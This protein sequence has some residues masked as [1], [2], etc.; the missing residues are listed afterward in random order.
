MIRRRLSAQNRYG[1]PPD[2]RTVM[3]IVLVPVL[4]FFGAMAGRIWYLAKYYP[5]RCHTL[6]IASHL[7]PA[8]L[9]APFPLANHHVA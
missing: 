2:Q 9:G 8:S 4:L 6:N 7:R 5:V 3:M 1:T